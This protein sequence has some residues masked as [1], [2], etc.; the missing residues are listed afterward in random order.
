[1]VEA[2]NGTAA[3]AFQVFTLTVGDPPTIFVNGYDSLYSYS[4]YPVIF[5][6]LTAHFADLVLAKPD[7]LTLRATG[8]PTPSFTETGPLPPGTS[9]VDNGNGTAT[10][11]GTPT[12]SGTFPI[13]VVA[14]NSAGTSLQYPG[15][16]QG[17]EFDLSVAPAVAPSFLSP[18]EGS[19]AT[20]GPWPW[21]GGFTVVAS[22]FPAP[23]LTETGAVPYPELLS[24][25]ASSESGWDPG[26][27]VIYDSQCTVTSGVSGTY[28]LT[29]GA[30]SSAGSAT[31]HLGLTLSSAKGAQPV[32]SSPNSTT[33]SPDK[34]NAFL[35]RQLDGS[36]GCVFTT[37]S[38]LPVGV[39]LDDWGLLSGVPSPSSQGSYPLTIDCVN[40]GST[41]YGSQSFTLNLA[42]GPPIVTSAP[43]ATFELG[44][45]ATFTIT[46]GGW[47][48]PAI[49][50]T[51]ALPP[52]MSFID[53]GDG[54]ATISGI[55]T[56]SGSY[57][58]GVSV[59]NTLG[60]AGQTLDLTVRD[61]AAPVFTSATSASFTKGVSGTFT[62]AASG[63]PTPVITESG[64]LPPG[65]TFNGGN[66]SGASSAVGTYPITFTASNGVSPD[67]TQSFFLTVGFYITTTS[68]PN[69]FVGT[70]YSQQLT[71][72]GGGSSV[73]WTKV[74]LPKGFALSSTG[75]LTGSPTS[76]AVGLL[77]VRVEASSNGGTPVTA[78]IPLTVDESPVFTSSSPIAAGFSEGVMGT[79]T[80]KANGYPAPILSETG[81]LPNGLTFNATTGV[82]SGD[83]PVTVDSAT[84]TITITAANGI[85]PSAS[86]P[87][88]I[89]VYAPLVI[90]TSTLPDATRGA[91]YDGTG[92]QFQA[93]GGI[94][95]YKWIR[96]GPLP[97]GLVLRSTGVLS[98]TPSATLAPGPYPIDVEVSVK[99]GK[100]TVVVSK[101][102]T[103]QIS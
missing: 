25:I 16:G 44:T 56:Q 35:I 64:T 101:T 39:T 87:F 77:V 53:N 65:V 91:A 71:T 48:A 57:P 31:Q 13:T 4:I 79:A 55:P 45:S 90:A 85:A 61:P 29:F 49:V 51:G 67:A 30:S 28:P 2:N 15:S 40:N 62:P 78:S 21:C 19:V 75:L 98:G 7:A 97:M 11:S 72:A 103:L 3:P 34:Y 70:A 59:S 33:F 81:S 1:V 102:L 26:T 38:P 89:T 47:P 84:Y 60:S 93:T 86:R 76:R 99:E 92:L 69:A 27:A 66:L 63:F 17:D 32:F 24:D 14:A 5:D 6:S 96:V 74:S 43:A 10:I 20:K 9:F 80:V 58:I 95:P 50:E 42:S 94:A 36:L 68:L 54:T 83:P 8:F 18:N 12:Q 46:T 73:L 100:A 88:T 41:V 22:G 23:Q 52:G 82:L 37:T